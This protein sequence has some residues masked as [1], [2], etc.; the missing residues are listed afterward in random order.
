MLASPLKP[1]MGL[2]CEQIREDR[3]EAWREATSQCYAPG[4]SRLDPPDFYYEEPYPHLPD[5]DELF[6]E[7]DYSADDWEEQHEYYSTEY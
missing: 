6:P 1:Y 2:T 7:V 5:S 3:A 4:S